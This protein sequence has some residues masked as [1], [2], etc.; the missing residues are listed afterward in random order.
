MDNLPAICSFRVNDPGGR[1]PVFLPI[2]LVYFE[3]LLSC[4]FP[5][6]SLRGTILYLYIKVL[7]MGIIPMSI[8]IAI[9]M[10]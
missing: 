10:P 7:I 4:P 6:F 9:I 8:S 3:Q 1:P 2:L 5:R